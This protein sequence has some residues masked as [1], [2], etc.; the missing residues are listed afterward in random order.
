MP[1]YAYEIFVG[2]ERIWTVYSTLQAESLC[3]AVI[4]ATYTKRALLAPAEGEKL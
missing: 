4:G 3:R 1:P 2:G